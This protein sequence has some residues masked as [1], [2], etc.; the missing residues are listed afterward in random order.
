MSNGSVRPYTIPIG[1]T[2]KM[3]D[4]KDGRDTGAPKNNMIVKLGS[5]NDPDK[6]GIY[7]YD[8]DGFRTL[9][10]ATDQIR[11]GMGVSV[12]PLGPQAGTQMLDTFVKQGAVSYTHL[13]LPTNREV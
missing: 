8:S 11:Q 3:V 13:T 2:V 1:T 12:N 9:E 6:P 5:A 10:P 7:G 4:P